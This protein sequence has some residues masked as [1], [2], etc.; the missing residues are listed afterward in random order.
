[1]TPETQKL[2]S[3]QSDVREVLTVLKGDSLGLSKGLVHEVQDT[4][5]RLRKLEGLKSRVMWMGAG[6]GLIG[7]LSIDRV[8]QFIKRVIITLVILFF[9]SCGSKKKIVTVS[10]VE[11]KIEIVKKDTSETRS[12]VQVTDTTRKTT[13]VSEKSSERVVEET[14]F[15]SDGRPTKYTKTT[16]RTGS[17]DAET[18][19]KKGLSADSVSEERKSSQESERRNIKTYDKDSDVTRSSDNP[20]WKYIGWGIILI[21]LAVAAVYVVRRLVLRR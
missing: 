7:G 8:I 1:M 10:K 20:V 16:E 3:I 9:I 5:A 4:K 17:R 19:E 14:T 13:K 11:E 15:D 21:A 6:A 18:N 12:T 2:E